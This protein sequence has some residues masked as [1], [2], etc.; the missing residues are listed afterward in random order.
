MASC[1]LRPSASPATE[2]SITQRPMH[3]PKLLRLRTQDIETP[4]PESLRD[5]SPRAGIVSS[6]GRCPAQVQ[7]MSACS[8]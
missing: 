1:E 2:Y 3:A 4:C 8:A 6:S 7:G 5:I